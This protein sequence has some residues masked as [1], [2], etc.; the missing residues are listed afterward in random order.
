MLGGSARGA[1]ARGHAFSA[2]PAFS[3]GLGAIAAYALGPI[4]RYTLGA[5]SSLNR[6]GPVDRDRSFVI[7][8]R[9]E[10]RRFL[11]FADGAV[12]SPAA[13]DTPGADGSN[14]APNPHWQEWAGIKA[15]SV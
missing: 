13:A 10:T 9:P 8:E 11:S 3:L 15:Q 7:L 1:Q 5:I 14:P 2:S 12:I 6:L 4:S